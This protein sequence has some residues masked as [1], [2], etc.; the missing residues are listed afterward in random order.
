MDRLRSDSY[1]YS[2][3]YGFLWGTADGGTVVKVPATKALPLL[4]ECEIKATI[5]NYALK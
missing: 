1:R 2:Y 3:W 4:T 5:L